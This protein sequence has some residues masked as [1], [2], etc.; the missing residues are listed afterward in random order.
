[1]TGLELRR[2]STSV[3]ACAQGR[4]GMGMSNSG[5]VAAGGGLVVDT[6][7]DLTLTRHMASLY[8]EVHTEPPRRIVNTHHNGDHCW[9]NQVFPGAEV[10]AHRGCADRFT[11]TSPAALDA[12]R[13]MADPPEHLRDLHEEL[14]PFDFTGIELAPPTTV[15]DGDTAL[16]LDGVRVDLIYAGPAHTE[17]DLIV[18]L[19]DEGV[20]LL[21]DVL[22]HGCT[23]VG[24]EGS[25]DQWI[26]SLR[27][28][29][30]LAPEHVVPGHGPVC[31]VAGVRAQRAYLEYVRDEARAAWRA[32]RSVLE[33]CAGLDF[34]PYADWDEPWR[35]AANV[36]RVYRECAGAAWDAPYDTAAVL[37]D[38]RAL[39]TMLTAP[40]AAT[41][42]PTPPSR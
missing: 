36:H 20:A 28:V 33:C 22:F 25:T 42:V 23:P 16:D 5:L 10:I 12:I 17:G 29:E 19:P 34:G 13:L 35:T 40:E 9:G 14:A 31:G 15:I 39:R 32:G 6:M 41:P 27:R 18:H 26:A 8:A 24:W 4:R 1:M 2:L 3:Y 7:F 38:T 37:R 11:A 30:E 21:G